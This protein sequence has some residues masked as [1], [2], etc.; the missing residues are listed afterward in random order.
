MYM[1]F[2]V[3]CKSKADVYIS[4]FVRMSTCT[5]KN[6]AMMD[7]KKKHE[8]PKMQV[9]FIDFICLPLYKVRVFLLGKSLHTVLLT[10][11]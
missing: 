3:L 11:P 8:L 2:V 4:S 5:L 10:G 9:G 7:R 6:Q 1:Y